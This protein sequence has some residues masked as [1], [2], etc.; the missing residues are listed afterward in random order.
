MLLLVVVVTMMACDA[1]T[2]R[3]PR[4]PRQRT[5]MNA[6]RPRRADASSL[7]SVQHIRLDNSSTISRPVFTGAVNRRSPQVITAADSLQC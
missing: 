5:T 6:R 4:S 3:T 2:A 1:S 7:W